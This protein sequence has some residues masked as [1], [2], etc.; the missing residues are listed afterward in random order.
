MMLHGCF[1]YLCFIIGN[2]IE[3]FSAPSCGASSRHAVLLLASLLFFERVGTF[4]I[5]FGGFFVR[6][7]NGV[8]MN[9]QNNLPAIS[10]MVGGGGSNFLSF[11][12]LVSGRCSFRVNDA[13]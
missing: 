3:D 7:A 11:P 5:P 6:L 2:R 1:F 4:G 9:R 12:S 10:P 13:F 8:G